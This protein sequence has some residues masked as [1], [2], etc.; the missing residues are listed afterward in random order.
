MCRLANPEE[1]R[2]NHMGTW[3]WIKACAKQNA[4]AQAQ[5]KADVAK[6]YCGRKSC[7]GCKRCMVERTTACRKCLL[8]FWRARLEVPEAS[9]LSDRNPTTRHRAVRVVHVILCCGC[10]SSCGV[11][12]DFASMRARVLDLR[13]SVS[14]Q[15]ISD[16][17][18]IVKNGRRPAQAKQWLWDSMKR[19]LQA[20]KRR[21]VHRAK[22]KVAEVSV[23]DEEDEEEAAEKNMKDVWAWLQWRNKEVAAKVAEVQASFGRFGSRRS[24]SI[25]LVALA[26]GIL[27]LALPLKRAA[28]KPRLK[29]V[30]KTGV[31]TNPKP[32]A[33]SSSS[34]RSLSSSSA[35]SGSSS[36]SSTSFLIVVCTA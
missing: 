20:W 4:G 5:L 17:L 31:K 13:L 21:T 28:L 36:G 15:T 35:S 23:E 10:V 19:W 8:S 22:R 26:A 25:T 30:Q 29:I 9:T 11:E 12:R 6:A 34:S 2:E 14:I 1:K 27:F 33:S 16:E 24:S 7:E 32:T 3:Q 18:W